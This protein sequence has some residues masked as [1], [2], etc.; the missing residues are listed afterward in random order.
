MKTKDVLLAL[1]AFG[2]VVAAGVWLR[3]MQA[4]RAAANPDP[5]ENNPWS[6]IPSANSFSV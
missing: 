2:V 1:A 6:V 3:K 4:A 5:T